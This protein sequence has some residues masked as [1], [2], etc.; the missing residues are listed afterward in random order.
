MT[1]PPEA[2]CRVRFENGRKIIERADGPA[3]PPAPS[4]LLAKPAGPWRKVV[5]SRGPRQPQKLITPAKLTD[6]LDRGE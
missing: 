5:G 2:I 3:P 1:T 4:A 6:E